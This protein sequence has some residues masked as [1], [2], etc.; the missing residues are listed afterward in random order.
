MEINK[1]KRKKKSNTWKLNNTLLKNYWVIEEIKD[2]IKKFTESNEN[3]NTSYQNLWDTAKAVLRGQ[4]IAINAHIQKEERAIIKTLTLQLEQVEREQQ[5]KPSGARRKEIIR[6][7]AELNEI[8]NRKTIERVNKTNSPFFD[9]I[10]KIDKPLAKLTKEKQERK[11]ITQIRNEMGDITTDP[12]DIKSIIETS[13]KTALKAEAAGRP[14]TT[15][16]RKTKPNRENSNPE[17]LKHQMKR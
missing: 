10:S 13:S 5:K 1:R 3:E 11:Q 16:I 12:T 14:S 8:E 2:G 4:F 15:K 6:I 7:R 17:T 9:K